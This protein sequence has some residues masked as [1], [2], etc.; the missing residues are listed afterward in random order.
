LRIG[1]CEVRRE[2]TR[3]LI[4]QFSDTSDLVGNR[5]IW[6]KM[7]Y[8]LTPDRKAS[9]PPKLTVLDGG[10]STSLVESDLS[11][12]SDLELARR[13]LRSIIQNPDIRDASRIQACMS[14]GKLVEW[15]PC[16][17]NRSI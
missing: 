17:G 14:L 3:G 15:K 4:E 9:D 10:K 13:T 12:L 1:K 5:L 16:L 8:S 11:D 2:G 7:R 6:L